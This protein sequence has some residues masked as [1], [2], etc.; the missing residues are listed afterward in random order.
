[1]RPGRS[2]VQCERSTIRSR[3]NGEVSKREIVQKAVQRLLADAEAMRRSAEHTRAGAFH[4]EN[5]AENDKDTRATEASYLA[6]GQAMRVEDTE[7]EATRLRFLE[8]PDFDSE[9]PIGL[10][11]LVE[12]DVEGAR[13]SYLI[14]PVAGG[15]RVPQTGGEV[16]LLTP[17]SPVG[18]AL[19][20]RLEGDVVEVRVRGALREHE[21]LSVR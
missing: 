20:G 2:C 6:R 11:A 5:R 16:T 3:Y 21:I 9:R 13:R 4:E 12:V 14:V 17:A 7:E 19:V 15:L 10:G 18:R 1:M 8:L